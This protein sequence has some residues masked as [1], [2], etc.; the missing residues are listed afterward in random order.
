[1]SLD[2]TQTANR[3]FALLFWTPGC[4]NG[5]PITDL[6]I[7]YAVGFHHPT[8]TKTVPTLLSILNATAALEALNVSIQ[9]DEWCILKHRIGTLSHS[10]YTWQ[11]DEDFAL[12]NLTG[13]LALIPIHPDVAYQFRIRLINRIGT[14]EPGPMAPGLNEE[15]QKRCLLKP[16]VPTVRTTEVKVYG[17]IP[18]TLTVSWKVND[19]F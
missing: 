18:N 19:Y 15:E 13:G 1:M 3:G 8:V 16:Q 6:Q 14:S 9:Q 7:E 11:A 12:V 2:C 4:D 5:A 17:N 10:S